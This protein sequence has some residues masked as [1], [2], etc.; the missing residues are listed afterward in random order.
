MPEIIVTTSHKSFDVTWTDSSKDRED[1]IPVRGY[2]VQ[3]RRK[4]KGI[5]FYFE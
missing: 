5:I 3:H 1:G 4:E 2:V